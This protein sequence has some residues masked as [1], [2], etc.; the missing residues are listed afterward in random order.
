MSD[1]VLI[2]PNVPLCADVTV[3]VVDSTLQ[4]PEGDMVQACLT[5]SSSAC[6]DIAVPFTTSGGTGE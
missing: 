4:L 1:G 6:E 2:V 5:V 3:T